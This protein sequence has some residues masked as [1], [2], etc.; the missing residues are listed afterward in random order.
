M[1]EPAESNPVDFGQTVVNL[2]HH[3]E[4]LESLVNNP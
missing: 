3:F 4:N 2:G 1:T